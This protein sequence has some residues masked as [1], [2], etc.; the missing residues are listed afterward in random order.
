M[1]VCVIYILYIL[2]IEK[3]KDMDSRLINI[4]DASNKHR[5][6][7]DDRKDCKL[8]GVTKVHSFDEKTV[9]IETVD[10]V[11]TI[12]GSALHVSRVSLERK[13]ADVDGRVDAL[14]YTDKKTMAS[15]GEG[16]IKRLFS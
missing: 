4:S 2:Y 10:G 12:K 16:L 14:I 3:R 5:I 7:L 8:T 15:K 13:E 6:S 1:T 11:I 9:V